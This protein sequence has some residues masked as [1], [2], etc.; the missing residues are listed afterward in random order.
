MGFSPSTALVILGGL[1]VCLFLLFLHVLPTPLV[2]FYLEKELKYC[3]LCK[4]IC[5][6]SGS[7]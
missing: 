1:Y 7:A 4:S 3:L 2:L 5:G 6:I